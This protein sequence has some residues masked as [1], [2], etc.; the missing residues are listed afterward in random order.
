MLTSW[1][2]A[3]LNCCGWVWNVPADPCVWILT[4]S[5]AGDWFGRLW[6][7]R[8][9]AAVF[10]LHPDCRHYVTSR[11]GVL[12]PHRPFIQLSFKPWPERTFPPL[13]CSVSATWWRAQVKQQTHTHHLPETKVFLLK[14][15]SPEVPQWARDVVQTVDACVN[16]H[17]VTLGLSLSTTQPRRVGHTCNPEAQV[18]ETG[19]SEVQD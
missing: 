6:T 5:S 11:L 16:T 4:R 12:L 8:S 18:I 13:S 10:S 7:A 9:W 3:W 15:K 19:G 1:T 14:L 17:K 2:F